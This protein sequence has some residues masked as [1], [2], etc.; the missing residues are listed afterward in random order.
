MYLGEIV[1]NLHNELSKLSDFSCED[2]S[3]LEQ[4][5]IDDLEDPLD[6]NLV[7]VALEQVRDLILTRQR[8]D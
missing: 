3:D 4:M 7:L 5:V 2:F 8:T 6:Q 1:E